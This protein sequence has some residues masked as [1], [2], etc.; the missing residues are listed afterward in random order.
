[1]KP[2]KHLPAILLSASL[3]SLSAAHA[4]ENKTIVIIDGKSID[5]ETFDNYIS[6]RVQ[7]VQHKGAISNEQ[8]KLLLEEYINSELLYNA[9]MKAGIDKLPEVKAE[10][11]MQTRTAIINSGLKNHLD[12]SLTEAA[13]ME[14]YNAKY[15]EGTAEYHTRH[16]LLENESDANNTLSALKRGEDFKKLAGISSIDPSSSEGGDLGWLGTDQMPPEFS[17]V[18]STLKPGEY[19]QIPV[20]SHFGWHIIM[21]DEKRT[22]DPPAIEMVAKEVASA[23]QNKVVLE[24]IDSLRKNATIEIK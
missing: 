10:I 1:M 16:I 4:E 9:A 22:I 6:M 20:Q 21:L 18:V 8:R 5:S 11:E 2:L 7:Q 3:L 24:Y 23:L 12:K 14:A 19:S 17:G 13:L 15:G